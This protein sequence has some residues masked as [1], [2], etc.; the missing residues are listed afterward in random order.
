LGKDNV[1][2]TVSGAQTYPGQEYMACISVNNSNY[3]L[4]GATSTLYNIAKA[5]VTLEWGETNLTYTGEK[6]A[7]SVKVN[8]LCGDDTLNV[9]V[10]GAQREAQEIPCFAYAK[11]NSDLY[12]I[13]GSCGTEFRIN[14]ADP[15][16]SIPTN[17]KGYFGT[18]LSTV[19]IPKAE[20]GYYR[21]QASGHFTW[22]NPTTELSTLGATETNQ[23][24]ATFTP[25]D[26]EN[27]NIV[28]NVMIPVEVLK[29]Y[30]NA[31]FDTNMPEDCSA[32]LDGV[33][34][35]SLTKQ[36]NIDSTTA[37]T[38]VHTMNLNDIPEI[39]MLTEKS[40][41]EFKGWSTNKYA[42]TGLTKAQMANT[43][44][45]EDTTYY[46]VW[47]PTTGL[48]PSKDKYND[49]QP[50]DDDSIIRF[51]PWDDLGPETF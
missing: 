4:N 34:L 29:D 42:T 5:Q 3:V 38:V 39:N 30:Y 25:D 40:G 19:T 46:A 11:I 45:S 12:E 18:D 33:E 10:S 17:V 26:A 20:R 44:I 28:K 37:E 51:R 21:T 49:N 8:G 43:T 48:W 14:K 22:D 2:P 41:Y 1:T 24:S 31:T 16:I 50:S 23:F 6:Q 36:L 32:S 47:M 27:F 35:K 9:E 15:V 13:A 7:P